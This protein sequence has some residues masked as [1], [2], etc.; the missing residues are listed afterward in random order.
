MEGINIIH[1]SF[2]DIHFKCPHCM[3]RHSDESEKYLNRCNK[4]KSGCTSVKCECGEKFGMTFDYKG[5]AVGF[6]LN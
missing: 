6:E 1:I 4:N 2:S 5:N 3:K